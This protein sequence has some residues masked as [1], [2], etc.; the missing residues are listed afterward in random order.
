MH[1]FRFLPIFL[2]LLTAGCVKNEITITF[3]LPETVNSPCRL[4]YYM[5]AKNVGIYKEVMAEIREGKGKVT[6]PQRYPSIIYLFSNSRPTPAAIIYGGRGDKFRVTGADENPARWEITGNAATDSLTAWR[7][8]NANLLNGTFNDETDKAVE[9][10][11][12]ANPDSPASLI[13]LYVYFNRREK[14][15]QFEKL[16][17]GISKKL[18][19]DKDLVGALSQADLMTR[20]T[21]P[22]D[23]TSA[24]VLHGA[25]GNADTLRLG[26]G[27]PTLLLFRNE[28]D[29]GENADSL[30]KLTASLSKDVIAELYA[31]PDSLAW[32]RHIKNDSIPAIKRLWL[33]LGESDSLAM[34]MGVERLPTYLIIGSDRKEKYRGYDLYEAITQLKKLSGN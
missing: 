11:V 33:P 32:Q 16:Q 8:R 2:L 30:R 27:A 17:S 24:V 25:D 9:T 31:D 3:S 6:L 10:Y 21:I 22:G 23:L 19:E 29:N 14:K 12:K 34:R 4:M 1:L 13:L 20:E 28:K 26:H 7:L 15:D 5:S 18:L